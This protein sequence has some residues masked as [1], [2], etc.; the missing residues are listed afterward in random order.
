MLRCKRL[1][2]TTDAPSH[3]LPPQKS[4]LSQ[5]VNADSYLVAVDDSNLNL[6]AKIRR[7]EEQTTLL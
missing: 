3:H 4:L 2:G 5:K 7:R 1:L 6:A